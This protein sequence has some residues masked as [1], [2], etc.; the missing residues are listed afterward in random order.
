MATFEDVLRLRDEVSG[1]LAKMSANMDSF[2]K[3]TKKTSFSL[4][5]FGKIA[6]DV[7]HWG[8]TRIALPLLAAGGAMVKLAMDME[9]TMSVFETL[10]G[11]GEK[12]QQM[13]ADIQKLAAETPLETKGLTDNAKLLLNFGY[14]AEKVVPALRML[15]DIAGGNKQRFDSLALAFAQV[16]ATGKLMGQDLLQMVNAGFNPLK[17]ISEQTG[18][19][20]ARLKDRMSKGKISFEQ[21]ENAMMKATSQGGKFFGLM[22]K[23]SRTA[24]GRLSTLMDNVQLLGIKLGTKLLPHIATVIEKLIVLVDKFDAL[25]ESTQEYIMAAGGIAIIAPTVVGALGSIA[26][27]LTVI[28]KHPVVFTITKIVAGLTALYKIAE[29]TSEILTNMFTSSSEGR[30]LWESIGGAW[31]GDYEHKKIKPTV[32][33]LA[34]GETVESRILAN[35]AE[36]YAYGQSVEDRFKDISGRESF[37]FSK[38]AQNFVNR[39]TQA[40]GLMKNDSYYRKDIAKISALQRPNQNT[41]NNTT[42]MTNNFTLNG[43]VRE[44][45]DIE[46]IGQSLTKQLQM[47]FSNTGSF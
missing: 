36:R 12:A 6:K 4:E 30:G 27:A 26:T 23:Q 5:K 21:V 37:D 13:V 15:G 41:T 7:G 43:T 10:L 22:E 32:K 40:V 25:D 1:K 44:E 45:A 19:S 28:E 8:Q 24:S 17:I 38:S 31:S 39:F 14:S 35:K 33:P 11:S 29:K 42:N 16:Q 34:P 2:D 46:K 18:I 47:A 3:K 20:M 9:N